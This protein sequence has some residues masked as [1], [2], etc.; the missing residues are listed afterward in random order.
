VKVH[1]TPK[2]IR[3]FVRRIILFSLVVS[4]GAG[5]CMAAIATANPGLKGLI[6]NLAFAL[7]LALAILFGIYAQ[8]RDPR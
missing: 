4:I 6:A 5:Y 8:L 7:V 3:I 2:E 1:A